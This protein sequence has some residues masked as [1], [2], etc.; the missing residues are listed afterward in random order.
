MNIQ[1]CPQVQ[2][3]QRLK[4]KKMR[5][6]EEIKGKKNH[7]KCTG[8]TGSSWKYYLLFVSKQPNKTICSE[9]ANIADF[10]LILADGDAFRDDML[11]PNNGPLFF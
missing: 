4:K 1:K 7:P 9:S 10:E 8:K 5:K 6:E 11:G 2:L 3:R